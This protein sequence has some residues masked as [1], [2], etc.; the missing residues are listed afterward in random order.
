MTPRHR[1][2]QSFS[3][4]VTDHEHRAGINVLNHGW[5]QAVA[6]SEVQGVDVGEAEGRARDHAGTVA[7]GRTS[8]PA[9][10]NSRF[11]SGM[12]IAPLWN[13]LA[14][15]AASTPACLNTSRKCS[16][17]PAPPEATSGT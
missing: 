17:L 7:T 9:A 5:Q 14:A 11:R 2:T 13:T 4:H 6:L 8:I 10:T 15:N 12:A 3:V 1:L 16:T